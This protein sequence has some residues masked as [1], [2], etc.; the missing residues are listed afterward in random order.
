MFETLAWEIGAAVSVGL[1]SLFGGGSTYN[2]N[3][4]DPEEKMLAALQEGEELEKWIPSIMAMG[5]TRSEAIDLARVI[6][7]T[8]AQNKIIDPAIAESIAKD[9]N[10][11]PA[12]TKKACE[13]YREL[14]FFRNKGFGD[15]DSLK[16]ITSIAD[17]LVIHNAGKTR[18]IEEVAKDNNIDI[19]EVTA[20]AN[21]LTEYTN[22]YPATTKP[23]SL[24][25]DVD[26]DDH[27]PAQQPASRSTKKTT[28]SNK[29]NNTPVPNN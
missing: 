1:D 5:T 29:N 9:V 10:M 2:S 6:H 23:F 16:R 7:R 21:L 13:C 15:I 19:K 12:I 24:N 8:L 20:V 3:E 11:D 22:L 27:Q 26:Q 17:K 14:T 4:E 28:G 18:S 25:V